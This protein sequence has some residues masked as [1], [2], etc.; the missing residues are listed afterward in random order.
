M[1]TEYLVEKALEIH[2]L[3]GLMAIIGQQDQES[4]KRTGYRAELSQDKLQPI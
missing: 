1:A 2:I 4:G 3:Y